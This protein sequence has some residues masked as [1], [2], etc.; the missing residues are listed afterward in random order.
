MAAEGAPAA[1]QWIT[2]DPRTK[3]IA[4]YD[5]AMSKTIETAFSGGSSNVQV[6]LGGQPF[7]VDFVKKCQRNARGG[8]RTIFR[9]PAPPGWPAPP[10][11][12]GPPGRGHAGH[13]VPPPA[14]RHPPPPVSRRHP[15]PSIPAID[16]AMCKE[17]LTLLDDY[18]KRIADTMAKGP[19]DFLDLDV[20][21]VGVVD[22]LA[23]VYTA[24]QAAL[25]DDRIKGKYG[26]SEERDAEIAWLQLD[27]PVPRYCANVGMV[28]QSIWQRKALTIAGLQNLLKHGPSLLK[29]I[30]QGGFSSCPHHYGLA[31]EGVRC[32]PERVLYYTGNGVDLDTAVLRCSDGA[33]LRIINAANKREGLPTYSDGDKFGESEQARS[34]VMDAAQPLIEDYC[35]MFKLDDY[36]KHGDGRGT[37]A[38]RGLLQNVQTGRL[39]EEASEKSG[40]RPAGTHSQT[41]VREG[42]RHTARVALQKP[43]C[44]QFP[45]QRSVYQRRVRRPHPGPVP[46]HPR[47]PYRARQLRGWG[48]EDAVAR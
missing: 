6:T 47:V 26:F 30:G 21:T 25:S 31:P 29:E 23:P 38:Y 18:E 5:T 24:I 32:G 1:P 10:D 27:Q 34:M 40:T 8:S 20:V 15:H 33:V 46:H 37:A 3:Q 4:P 17:L 11:A 7:T 28:G 22:K 48:R 41:A 9:N 39:R 12:S 2:V 35:R 19:P 44:Q 13:H 45:R 42:Q 14:R 36:A 43:W 16:K